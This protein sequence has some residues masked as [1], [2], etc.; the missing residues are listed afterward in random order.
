[1]CI[2]DIT[3]WLHEVLIVFYFLT[4]LLKQTYQKNRFVKMNPQMDFPLL[5]SSV[6]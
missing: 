1:M 4:G 2:T 3:V 6:S 5:V